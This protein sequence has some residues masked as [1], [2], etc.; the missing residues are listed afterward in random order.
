MQAVRSCR[1][2]LVNLSTKVLRRCSRQE[3][4]LTNLP[5][6]GADILSLAEILSRGKGLSDRP[7]VLLHLDR[8]R[9]LTL[10]LVS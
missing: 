1:R 6:P 10:K 5:Y 4:K 7:C 9:I 8:E 3:P 2:T